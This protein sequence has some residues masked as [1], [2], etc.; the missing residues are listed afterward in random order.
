[1]QTADA[2]LL[3]FTTFFY[4]DKSLSLC[5]TP[6]FNADYSGMVFIT[7]REEFGIIN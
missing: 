5:Y 4:F 3:R 2:T 6:V 7:S 1:M